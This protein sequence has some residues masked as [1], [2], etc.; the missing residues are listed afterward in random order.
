MGEDP[1]HLRTDVGDGR[2]IKEPLEQEVAVR[3]EGGEDTSARH[4]IRLS[5]LSRIWS[6]VSL[7]HPSVHR[8]VDWDGAFAS[9]LARID[10]PG[11]D[12]EVEVAA[13]LGVLGDPSTRL[14]TD[15]GV[16]VHR[17][18]T[19][20]EPRLYR[21]DGGVAVL[22]ATDFDGWY[23]DPDLA[24]RLAALIEQGA[25]CD[26][27]VLDLRDA[28]WWF[29][30]HFPGAMAPLIGADVVLPAERFRFHSG[31]ASERPDAS[32]G[33]FSGTMVKDAEVIQATGARSPRP[34]LI[35]LANE[36]SGRSLRVAA[37]VA[38]AGQGELVADGG[39]FEPGSS[40][41]VPLSPEVR[42]RI[43]CSEWLGAD[44]RVGLAP[45]VRVRLAPG[46]DPLTV[47]A[48][49]VDALDHRAP[50]A[51]VTTN[52]PEASPPLL[53]AVCR[54]ES[55]R[56]AWDGTRAQRLMGLFRLHGVLDEFFAYPALLGPEWD[57][58]LPRLYDEVG[59]AADELAFCRAIAGLLRCLPDS[60]A[61]VRAPV[62]RRHL[63]VA[64]PGLRLG[65]VGG[66]TVV[67]ESELP[68]IGPGDLIVGI[69]AG[70][71]AERRAALV[72]WLPA[73]T[74]Q[75]LD[76]SVHE[77]L[78][79]GPSGSR[80]R[81]DVLSS[82]GAARSVFVKRDRPGPPGR[83]RPPVELLSGGIG[84]VDL[85]RTSEAELQGRW[86]TLTT[87]RAFVF[88]LRGYTLGAIWG[89]V[90]HLGGEP[91]VGA[92]FR[93]REVRGFG[94]ATRSQIEMAKSLVP[95]RSP[96]RPLVALVDSATVSQAEYTA[97]LLRAL[98]ARLVGS[99]TNGTLGDVVTTTVS[100][101]VTA[102]FTGQATV[103]ADG[104]AVHG[105]GILPDRLVTPSVEGLLARRDEVLDAALRL[106]DGGR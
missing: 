66:T 67:V 10:A 65:T 31:W 80:V 61:R 35:L 75:A 24:S 23:L 8:T 86:S 82:D 57:A 59:S 38:A 43:R 39:P 22:V 19:R 47:A 21:S 63:G 55:A 1:Q 95:D 69:E 40:V 105:T 44:G 99:P 103:A 96:P 29:G 52:E 26:S 73:S 100:A 85:T 90:G 72:P 102:T 68:N 41:T 62:V 17:P 88:D 30:R 70:S 5:S 93:R 53:H 79:A 48:A 106:L 97:L 4:G 6:T 71:V 91:V 25:T 34:R 15:Q 74:P 11:I 16:D 101:G 45:R 9:F 28:S 94:P 83:R 49:V 84:Y 13:L 56:R 33:L 42:V 7:L 37:G 32:G 3:V 14:E 54:P 89:L 12:P 20:R 77:I 2:R 51:G 76:E 104:E 50:D 92:R 98:G 81:L 27:F 64:H 46:G 78:L 87:A 18:V 58:A 36:R 60:H